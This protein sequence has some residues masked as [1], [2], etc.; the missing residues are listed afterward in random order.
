VSSEEQ[1]VQQW[2][3]LYKNCDSNTIFIIMGKFHDFGKIQ[4][5]LSQPKLYPLGTF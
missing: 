1:N 5:R 4:F 2:T 3:I